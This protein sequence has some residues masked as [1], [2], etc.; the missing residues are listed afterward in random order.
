MDA[1]IVDVAG[2]I[3]VGGHAVRA[4]DLGLHHLGESEDGVE[5]RAQLVAHLREEARL[6]DV[7]RFRAAARLVGD[8][9]RGLELADQRVL[10]GARLECGELR[11]VEAVRQQREIA[12]RGD[13][14]H[15]QDVVLDRAADREV[16]R[17][18]GG[19]RRGRRDHRH[20]H[21]R[22]QR[23]RQRHHQQ[24]DEQHEGAG[25]LLDPDRMD[26][27]EHPGHAR[28]TGRA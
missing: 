19:D 27:D 25:V 16:E 3:L 13:R 17:H 24:H 4:E 21:A 10:L 22:R 28:R 9:L 23:R 7:G 8:R 6:G 18:R 2:I 15:R 1:G 14:E 5:R 12:L 26:Q 20:R 11:G